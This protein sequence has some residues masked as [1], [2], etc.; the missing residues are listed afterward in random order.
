MGDARRWCCHTKSHIVS[1]GEWPDV[2]THWGRSFSSVMRRAIG[3]K[4][5]LKPF[6]SS[7]KNRHQRQHH[8]KNRHQRQ[9]HVQT[10]CSNEPV[11]H[12]GQDHCRRRVWWGLTD[13]SGCVLPQ[14]RTPLACGQLCGRNGNLP[15]A[16]G[17]KLRW[18]WEGWGW[19][20]AGLHRATARACTSNLR[21]WRWPVAP[22][23]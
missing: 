16:M 18:F 17:G 19:W 1:I 11:L 9:H 23:G 5:P 8:M 10:P 20:G 2:L 21:S 12:H 4:S 22:P 15:G 14:D 7:L 3:C 13:G 6:S